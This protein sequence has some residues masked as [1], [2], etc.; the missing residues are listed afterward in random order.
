MSTVS[1]GASIRPL[2]WTYNNTKDDDILPLI[3]GADES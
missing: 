2:E 3:E 1:R